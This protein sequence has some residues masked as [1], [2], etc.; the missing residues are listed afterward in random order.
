[1]TSQKVF[2]SYSHPDEQ[3]ARSFA[4]N[5]TKEGVE[6]WFDQFS[7]KPGA[8]LSAA[9]EK[10]LRQSSVVVLV[11]NEENVERPNLFFELGAALGMNKVVIPIVSKG[12]EPGKLPLPLRMVRYLVRTSPK[13]TARE[14]AAALEVQHDK[15]A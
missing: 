1:M 12:L 7:V 9:I 11:L 5:L 6:V 14:V 2:I 10:G 3:W 8:S 15:A 13:E 4:E